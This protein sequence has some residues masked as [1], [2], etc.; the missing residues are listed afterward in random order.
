MIDWKKIKQDCPKAWGKIK[1]Y[2]FQTNS[3]TLYDF[4]DEQGINVF[5][6]INIETLLFS[7]EIWDQKNQESFV[8]NDDVDEWN[9]KNRKQAEQAAFLKAFEI[10]EE[11]LNDNN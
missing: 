1:T 11:K 3:R 9:F 4:F 10:L 6:M 5:P 7:Y 2:N 8:Y